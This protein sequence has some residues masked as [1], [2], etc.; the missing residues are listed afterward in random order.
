VTIAKGRPWGSAAVLP[1]DGVLVHSDAELSAAVAS[2]RTSGAPVP[3]FGLLGGDLCR[4]LGGRGEEARLRSA[5]AVMFPIDIGSVTADGVGH[6]FVAH[7][8][9]RNRWWTRVVAAMNASWLGDWNVAPRSHP[10]D[11]LLDLFDARLRLG[12]LRQVRHRVRLGAHL[13]HPRIRERRTPSLTVTLDRTLPIW[14]D[15]RRVGHARELHFA[16]EPDAVRV[17]V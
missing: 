9:A 3:I 5:A 1:E 14:V 2:A 16:L 11:G 6:S 7:A 10:N 15:G 13:P 12:D 17:V 4:T 8:V